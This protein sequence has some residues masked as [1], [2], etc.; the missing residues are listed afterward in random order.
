MAKGGPAGFPILFLILLVPPTS[1]RWGLLWRWV[2]SGA[3]LTVLVL[4]VWW[5]YV[6][7][8]PAARQIAGELGQFVDGGEHHATFLQYFPQTLAAVAPWTGFVVVAIVGGLMHWRDDPRH[9]VPLLWAAAV[10][11]PLLLLPK[12]Q[13]HYLQPLLPPL[14]LLAGHLIARG[15]SADGTREERAWVRWVG[16]GTAGLAIL[17]GPT[18]LFAAWKVQGDLNSTD[19]A[20]ALFLTAA[21]GV[22]LALLLMRRARAGLLTFALGVIVVMPVLFGLWLPRLA[23]TDWRQTAAAVSAE[24]GDAPLRFY[25]PEISLP[26]CFH[27]RRAIP[28]L[29]DERAADEFLAANPNGRLIVIRP[30]ST[31]IRL[32]RGTHTGGF[33]AIAAPK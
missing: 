9:R 25:G 33:T 7:F 28:A 23:P 24:V 13:D 14:M 17:G 31:S 18:I 29:P 27:L 30:D 20:L 5:L 16:V 8:S 11:V 2:R 22:S 10:L 26:L 1:G 6:S 3:P 32:L 12:R 4:S 19:W 15:T 21:A